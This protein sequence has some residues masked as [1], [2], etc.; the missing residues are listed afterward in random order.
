LLP[1]PFGVRSG[2]S[3]VSIEEG[4]GK[5]RAALSARQDP[6][7]VVVGRTSAIAF[8]SVEDAIARAN[9]Y[10]ATGIDAMFFVGIRTRAQLDAIASEIKIPIL[11]GGAGAEVY[12]R[13]YLASRGVRICLQGHLPF[14]A[15]VRA[16][17]ETLKALRDGTAPVDIRTAASAEVMKRVTREAEYALWSKDFLGSE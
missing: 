4:V 11:L 8:A 3:L 16:V 6:R 15:G 10:A 7:L 9:A 13:D 5:M 2:K 12:D 14:L 17:Y 1:A